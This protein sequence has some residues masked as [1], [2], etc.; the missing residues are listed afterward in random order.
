MQD[1]LAKLMIYHP[2]SPVSPNVTFSIGITEYIPNDDASSLYRRADMALYEA[3]HQGR[4]C[5]VVA[6]DQDTNDEQPTAI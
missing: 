6:A 5:F 2:A 1:T 4:N 3:K